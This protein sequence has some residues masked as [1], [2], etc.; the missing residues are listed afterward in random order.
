MT[1]NLTWPANDWLT[2]EK[3]FHIDLTG[4]LVFTPAGR[5]RLDRKTKL[6]MGDVIVIPKLWRTVKLT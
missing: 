2:L 3:L 6:Q 5:L 4:T 1:G